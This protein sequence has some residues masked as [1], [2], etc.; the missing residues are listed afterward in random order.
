MHDQKV[1][2]SKH[3]QPQSVPIKFA[4]TVNK[5]ATLSTAENVPTLFIFGG[6]EIE[7]IVN[8]SKALLEND[9]TFKIAYIININN[10]V[11]EFFK[12]EELPTAVLFNTEGK[13][14]HRFNG[15]PEA[16]DLIAIAKSKIQK[17]APLQ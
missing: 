5:D 16:K 12:I 4:G 11:K 6:S 13:E 1:N 7:G 10:D 17:E 3:S 15:L 8:D 14:I 9:N 2:A